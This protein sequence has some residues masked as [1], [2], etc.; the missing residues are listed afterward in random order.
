MFALLV[1][2]F[3]L[4][5]ASVLTCD[6]PNISVVT[7][8]KATKLKPRKVNDFIDKFFTEKCFV[9]TFNVGFIELITTR[10]ATFFIIESD[11]SVS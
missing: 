9:F 7:K 5:F 1:I 4:F 2:A 3:S 10:T 11:V 6:A 8:G